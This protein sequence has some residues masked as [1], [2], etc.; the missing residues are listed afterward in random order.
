MNHPSLR[1]NALT[2][3]NNMTTK[4]PTWSVYKFLPLEE[5]ER[6]HLDWC[7]QHKK[8][9]NSEADVDEFY[10]EIDSVPEPDPNAPP[11]PYTGKP[12]GRPRKNPE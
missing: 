9:P 10:D 5:R 3:R 2:H 11:P 6:I 1:G 8:N 7:K 12:R 4:L